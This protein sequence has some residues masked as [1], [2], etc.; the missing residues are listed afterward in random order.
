MESLITTTRPG[1]AERAG[2][3]DATDDG[4]SRCRR[5]MDSTRRPSAASAC[6][7]CIA[8]RVRVSPPEQHDHEEAEAKRSKRRAIGRPLQQSIECSWL[9]KH[10]NEHE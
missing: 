6:S 9:K 1:P 7:R 2:A 4:N 10:D 3:S 8:G 5:A